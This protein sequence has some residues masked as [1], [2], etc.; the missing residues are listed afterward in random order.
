MLDLKKLRCFVAVAEELNFRKAAERLCVAQP[1][2]TRTI[3]ALEQA[4]GLRLFER[5]QRSVSLTREGKRFYPQAL[6]LLQQARLLESDIRQLAKGYSGELI[7]GFA[8]SVPLT[9]VFSDIIGRFSRLYPEVRLT[10]EDVS[11]K[12]Q[13]E[14]VQDGSLDIGFIRPQGAQIPPS[15]LA[16]ELLAEPLL[17]AVYDDHPLLARPS[18][19]LADLKRERFLMFPAQYGSGLNRRIEQLC[20]RAGFVPE[21][22]MVAQQTLTLIALVAARQG[23]AI[24]PASLAALR[25]PGVQYLKL[26]DDDCTESMV[27]IY[28]REQLSAAARRFVELALGPSAAQ[29]LA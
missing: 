18:V 26:G 22:G 6:A 24:V 29:A 16:Y 9:D 3:S 7:I 13:I 15:L 10:F 19:R 12:T 1:P 28:R 5:T 27:L 2:L 25:K 14:R 4:L 20:A 17:L 23:V 8:S 21:I 11:S